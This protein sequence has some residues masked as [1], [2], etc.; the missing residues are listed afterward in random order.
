MTRLFCFHM[1]EPDGF[2]EL[3]EFCT[4][5]ALKAAQDLRKELPID[6]VA[7]R[8]IT[9][10]LWQDPRPAFVY[11]VLDEVQKAGISIKDWSAKLGESERKPE[12]TGHLVRL[13]TQWQQDEQSFRARKLAEILVDLIC[14]SATNESDYYR[15][16]LWLKEFDS[17]VRSLNDQQEFF[18]FKRRNSEFSLEWRERDIKQIEKRIDPLKRW[19]LRHDQTVF[20]DKWRTSGIPFSLFRQRYIRILDLGLPNELAVVGKS[21]IHAYGMSADVHF[22][23]HDSSSAFD[24]D[25][26]YLGVDRVGLLCYAIL[27]RCQKLLELVPAGANATIRTMHDE[28]SGPAALIAQ[29][30]QEKAQIGDFVWAH[31]DIGRVAEVRKS[32]FGYVSYRVTYVEAPPIPEISEDWFAGFEVQVSCD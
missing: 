21:Y 20:R 14:F 4:T 2:R 13:V 28:N 24:Q 27:I 7:F 22:T 25:D 10:A 15:D 12:H 29:L 8:Q 31:G 19:Y 11:K 16:C 32:K 30:K 6:E 9:P 5:V 1:P 17:T 26:I 18:G 23:P 3:C